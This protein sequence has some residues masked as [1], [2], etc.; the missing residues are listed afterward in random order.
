MLRRDSATIRDFGKA[1]LSVLRGCRD[2]NLEAMK[3]GKALAG[4]FLR[5]RRVIAFVPSRIQNLNI[6]LRR[7]NPNF[8]NP[9]LFERQFLN[10]LEPHRSK[11]GPLIFEICSDLHFM[12]GSIRIFLATDCSSVCTQMVILF[13][14][15]LQLFTQR[16]PA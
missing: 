1:D 16:G 14:L 13:R 9:E 15:M 6:V 8:L 5:V 7:Q 4:R 2:L 11:V 3:S 12:P 10:P